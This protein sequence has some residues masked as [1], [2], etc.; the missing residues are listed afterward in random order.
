MCSAL[1]TRA[2]AFALVVVAV[3]AALGVACGDGAAQPSPTPAVTRVGVRT[4]TPTPTATRTAT[5]TPT[6]TATPTPG[7]TKL[8]PTGFPLS[9]G[10]RVDL[11]V[12]KKGSRQIAAAEG[13]TVA[14][15]AER[16]QTGD[17]PVAA[18]AGGWNCRTHQEYEGKP[19]VDWYVPEGKPVYATLDGEATL[20]IVTT[21]NAFDVYGVDREPYYGDPDRARAPLDPFGGR[22]GGG[23]G[24]FVHIE[25]GRFAAN[26]G[27]LS[28]RRTLEVVPEAA[29]LAPYSASYDYDTVFGVPRRFDQFDAIA[30]WEVH[31]GDVIGYTG[32]TGYS[33]AP[34][35]HYEVAALGA[36]P[37][38][39]CPTREEGFEDGGWLFR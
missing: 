17:D 39:L 9:A 33:E 19:A 16:F 7:R 25:N 23:K 36:E 2:R 22:P 1:S 15:Y 11:V 8:E 29:F 12:G 18:N 24:V 37:R 27:H 5:A 4:L 28:L 30:R 13:P 10:M 3:G 6:T 21:A 14:D 35:L 34:H 32:D 38:W 31:A 26:Y 20:F